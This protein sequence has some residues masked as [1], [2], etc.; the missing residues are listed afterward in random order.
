MK[1]TDCNTYTWALTTASNFT[2]QIKIWHK[3]DIQTNEQRYFL[4]NGAECTKL[5]YW[6][7][8]ETPSENGGTYYG[9]RLIYKGGGW[10]E[11]LLGKSIKATSEDIDKIKDYII[12]GSVVIAIIALLLTAISK[13]N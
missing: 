7:N 2:E 3:L 12:R 9:A 10:L 6:E 4:D 1:K 5:V 11:K 13:H 8:Y